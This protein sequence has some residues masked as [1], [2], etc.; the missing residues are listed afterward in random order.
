MI[1]PVK[2]P[3]KEDAQHIN[4]FEDM[5]LE[6]ISEI[7]EG[8]SEREKHNTKTIGDFLKDIEKEIQQNS[9]AISKEESLNRFYELLRDYAGED[10]LVSSFD[11]LE[12]LKNKPPEKKI[13]S[14]YVK[15]D[16][17]LDGFRMKQLVVISAATKSG[18]C[19]KK[20]TK[21]IMA[22]TSIKK[23]EDIV[24]GDKLMGPDSTPRK[25]LALGRGKDTLY[26]VT[27][28]HE[29]FI[30][31]G[32]HI[33][34]LRCRIKN[35]EAY[36]EISIREFVNKPKFFR[37]HFKGFFSDGVE[38]KRKEVKVDPYFLGLWLGDGTSSEPSI[39]NPEPELI[40]YIQNYCDS[41][42]G[43]ITESEKRHSFCRKFYLKDMN[44]K[45]DLRKLGI[46]DNK[47][48]P[49][50]YLINSENNRLKLLAG[51]LDT[52]G[53]LTKNKYPYYEMI[54]KDNQLAKDIVFLCRSLG[55]RVTCYDKI[56]KLAT[57]DKGRNYK[58]ITI[59]GDLSKIPVIVKRKQ[60]KFKPK[61][62]YLSC[63]VEIEEVG[64]GEYYGF[65]LDKDGLFILDN[66]IVTHNTSLCIEL[67]S[68][69]KELNPMWLPFEEPAEELIQKFLD[70]REEPPLF[71]TP[72]NMAG[73]TLLWVEKKIIEAKAKFNSQIVFIDHLHFIVPMTSD[74]QDLAIGQA[75]RELKRMAKQWNVI[76]FLIAHIKKSK[77]E[78]APDLGD[79]RDSSFVAQEAD[80]VIMLWRE[81][82][83]K[84]NE[85]TISNNVN[86]SV[87]A[88]RR[89]GKTGNMKLVYEN[90]KFL[91]EDWTKEVKE[92]FSKKGKVGA[93][94]KDWDEE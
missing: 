17:I 48:I 25:V 16:E 38:F 22:D 77:V 23:V 92:P 86:L 43:K 6:Q 29:S 3:P 27:I 61:K 80:T 46:L 53:H 4:P 74:R 94:M 70:R 57:W 33:L 54:M 32:D 56:V 21:I 67:T 78:T 72:N 58:R 52:D 28:G 44:L 39:T 65:E 71:Y 51:L 26:R 45:D 24:I 69:M 14:G 75:M 88:N 89:T 87:Q 60:S 47:N 83:R 40:E 64:F 7:K 81:T 34:P 50:E 49:K 79:L 90:G 73:N 35:R 41:N 66:F 68:R 18:K 8:V 2:L 1:K 76:I 82:N 9:K 15:L 10:K 12:R 84:N 85:I 37:K 93:S 13:M 91:E 30:A 55:Y 20:G 31:N 62:D 11:I 36:K 19:V 5:S 42:G 59:R 63:H